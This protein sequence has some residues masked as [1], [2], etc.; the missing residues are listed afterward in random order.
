RELL[1]EGR[2]KVETLG[3]QPTDVLAGELTSRSRAW[4]IDGHAADVAERPRCLECQE[5]SIEAGQLL[6]VSPVSSSGAS[7]S[8]LRILPVGPFG[9]SSRNQILVGH[10]YLDSFSSAKSRISSVEA[11]SFSLST[12]AAATSSPSRSCSTPMT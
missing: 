5:L 12:T 6:H 4:V 1:R 2:Q 3:D 8:R 10:L 7:S 11:L 9:S